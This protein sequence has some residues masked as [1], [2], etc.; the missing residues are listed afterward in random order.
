[1]FS[2]GYLKVTV[3]TGT[4]VVCKK[5][6]WRAFRLEKILILRY[7]IS[8][9][10]IESFIMFFSFILHFP[11]VEMKP[12]TRGVNILHTETE[13]EHAEALPQFVT[14]GFFSNSC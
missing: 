13:T 6:E 4:A 7:Y 9:L 11:A 12:L 8:L 10:A 2:S 1:M 14:V 5:G 3:D